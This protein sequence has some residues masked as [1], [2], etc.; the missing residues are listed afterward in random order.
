MDSKALVRVLEDSMFLRVR[1]VAR[2]LAVSR[3]TVYTLMRS[4]ELLSIKVRGSRRIPA[5][6]LQ[7]YVEARME[8]AV[9]EIEERQADAAAEP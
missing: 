5:D 8:D 4:G 2:R 7:A 3:G 9:A 1:E 6:A